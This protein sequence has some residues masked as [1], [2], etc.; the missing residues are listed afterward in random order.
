MPENTSDSGSSFDPIPERLPYEFVLDKPGLDDVLKVGLM[1][2]AARGTEGMLEA[3]VS[4]SA[5]VIDGK[6]HV[7][8]REVPVSSPLEGWDFEGDEEIAVAWVR[9]ED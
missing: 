9:E 5:E 2:F 7:R 6:L 1:A 4:M 3:H 8:L